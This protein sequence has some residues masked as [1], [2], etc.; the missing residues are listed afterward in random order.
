MCFARA[1][2]H[3]APGD[4]SARRRT[5]AKQPASQRLGSATMRAWLFR[6]GSAKDADRL[7]A[8]RQRLHPPADDRRRGAF[9]RA[10]R[11]MRKRRGSPRPVPMHSRP[12][13]R[14]WRSSLPSRRSRRELIAASAHGHRT[15]RCGRGKP[16]GPPKAVGASLRDRRTCLEIEGGRIPL[17]R[18]RWRSGATFVANDCHLGP[19]D[20][21]WL[22]TGP[23]WAA[24]P[25][26]SGRRR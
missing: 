5:T 22:I 19:G 24:N 16:S 9:Q 6:R 20:R 3:G 8:G 11:S 18:A 13:T 23:T 10:R 12:R 7:M 15:G 17:W 14:I 1:A 25:L 4:C 2:L 21:L 26:S